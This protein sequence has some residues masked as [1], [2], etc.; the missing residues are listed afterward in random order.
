MADS[1]DI[2]SHTGRCFIEK[3]VMV[4]L[5][6]YCDG[7]NE[8]NIKDPYKYVSDAIKAYCLTV[9]VDRFDVR[10]TRFYNNAE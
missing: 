1:V 2:S 4:K 8:A 7:Q 9:P 3:I 10:P 6:C 5:V